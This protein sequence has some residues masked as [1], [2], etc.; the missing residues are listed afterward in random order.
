MSQRFGAKWP[1]WNYER[2][3]SQGG[4]NGH[5]R[6]IVYPMQARP[7]LRTHQPNLGTPRRL[8][9]TPLFRLAKRGFPYFYRLTLPDGH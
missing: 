9:P 8:P 1:Q 4:N 6:I 3:Q 5:T 2:F 7:K